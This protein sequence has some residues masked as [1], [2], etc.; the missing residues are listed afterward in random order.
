MLAAEL[1]PRSLHVEE[2]PI[3]HRAAWLEA[4]RPAIRLKRGGAASHL[5]PASRH[6][7]ANR[8]GLYL[9]HLWR[10]GLL[11]RD[12]GVAEL[13]TPP[14]VKG[15]VAELGVRVRSVT[16]WNSVYKLRRASEL[17][18]TDTDF[19]WLAEIERDI[20]VVMQPRSKDDRLVMADRL[21]EAGLALIHDA[22][23]SAKT[24]NGQAR[25]VR[26]GL[27]IALLALHPLRIKNFGTLRIG[28]TIRRLEGQLWLTVRARDTKSCRVDVRRV[29][30]FMNATIDRYVEQYRPVLF[31]SKAVDATFWVS[32]TRG[33][34]FTVKNMGTL[35]TR[36]TMRTVGVD[37]SP[38]LFRMAAA[39]MAAIEKPAMPSLGANILGHRDQY[40]T[41]K[42]YNRPGSVHAGVALT[43]IVAAYRVPGDPRQGVRRSRF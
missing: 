29:P 42:H 27:M 18:A 32:S 16:L 41:E 21:L 9:D 43:E 4:C 23:V 17:M 33:R 14:N 7:I 39:S 38:H 40:T 20:A 37:V 13:V 28:E 31:G 22:E 1:R 6:D 15:F 19:A 10:N 8:Y 24:A 26:N 5:A 25:G 36:I 2:W 11:N 34:Q 12:L 3:S 30:E 35:I